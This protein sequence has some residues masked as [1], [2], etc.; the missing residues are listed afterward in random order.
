MWKLILI[1][2]F[3]ILISG[4]TPAAKAFI[5]ASVDQVKDTADTG[6]FVF[7]NAPCGMTLGAY[8]RLS[9]PVIKKGARLMCDPSIN[10][11]EKE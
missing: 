6:A 11:E 2:G 5:W 3:L 9:N 8:F 10:I 7:T 4:C 1:L